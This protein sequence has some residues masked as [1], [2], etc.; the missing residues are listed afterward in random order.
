M[1]EY[2]VLFHNHHSGMELYQALKRRN[3][4]TT[5]VPTPRRVSACCGISLMIQKEDMEKIVECI[6]F[7]KIEIQKIVALENANDA[8]RDRYC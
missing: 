6:E 2:Y 5:I 3:I 8:K 7:D 4:Q 1:E